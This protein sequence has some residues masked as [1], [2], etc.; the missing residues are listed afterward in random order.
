[1]SNVQNISETSDVQVTSEPTAALDVR[2]MHITLGHTEILHGV[3]FSVQAGELTCLLGS[4]G[5][6]K[7]T[8]LRGILGLERSTE[9]EVFV[10]GNPT[11]DLSDHDRALLFAY[12]PQAHTPTFAYSVED[13]VML[14]RT[15]HLDRF[16][17][18]SPEDFDAAHEAMDSLGILDLA[19]RPYT[20]LSGGQRQLTLIARALAQ[21]PRVLVMDEPTAS[22]DFGNQLVVLEQ[23][24]ELANEGMAV[25]VVTH[26][27]THALTFADSV[28]VLEAGN[29][30]TTGKPLEVLDDELL[31]RIYH[32]RVHVAEVTVDGEQVFVCVP[33]HV[34]RAKR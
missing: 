4:N 13:V 21:Q 16:S 9:G 8:T 26:D 28:A 15:P 7:T 29:I 25:L 14:G 19:D 2:N 3:T 20:H 34:K 31:G 10:D 1:M 24:R 23:I 32:A 27:P 18:P 6:G 22:L 33:G 11:L 17:H 12:V 30:I 5:S